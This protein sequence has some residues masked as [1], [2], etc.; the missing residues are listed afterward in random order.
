MTVTNNI[1]LCISYLDVSRLVWNRG[2]A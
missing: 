2:F 1:E